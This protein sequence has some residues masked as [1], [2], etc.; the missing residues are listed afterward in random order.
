[1]EQVSSPLIEGGKTY[2][3]FSLH[4]SLVLNSYKSQ[5]GTDI[6]K[7][8]PDKYFNGSAGLYE[9]AETTYQFFYPFELEGDG[10]FYE[11]ITNNESYYN[12]ERWEWNYLM[13]KIHPH[14]KVLEIGAGGLKFMQMLSENG[15]AVDGLEINPL[16]LKKAKELGLNVF[17]SFI[18]DFAVSRPNYYNVVC[19]FHVLEHVSDV[20]SFLASAVSVLKPG[21]RLI[22]SVPNNDS[23]LR[24]D[25]YLAM[26]M[27]PHHMGR[28]TEKSLW[29]ICRHFPLEIKQ[30]HKQEYDSQYNDLHF[31]CWYRGLAYR[32]G[33]LGK[34]YGRIIKPFFLARL[35]SRMKSLVGPNIMVEYIRK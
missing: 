22:I 19:S 30:V 7:F 31:Q 1:M 14:E 11:H 18:Q 3:C 28:W 8:L 16:S 6:S 10:P 2:K 33:L 27:P 21:G 25:K 9:C 34:V 15:I 17:D 13:D 32:F 29:L 26:N 5:V 20:K 4:K 23:F 12:S 35:K 24:L